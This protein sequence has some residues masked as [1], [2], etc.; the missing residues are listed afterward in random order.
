MALRTARRAGRLRTATIAFAAASA[1]VVTG[2]TNTDD[3]Q[4]DSAQNSVSTEL[5]AGI[6]AAITAALDYST[7]TAAIVGVWS[8]GGDYV[9]AYGDE[10]TVVSQFRGAQ[11][12]QP[13]MCALL[14]DLAADG[15]V[16]LTR[17]VS[18]DLPRQVGIA[19]IT[20][21]QLCT[22]Q[23]GLADFKS[24]FT[25]IV[26][27]NP[28]REWADREL[29]AQSLAR[30]PLSWP[31]LNVHL[32]DTNAVLLERALSVATGIPTNELLEERVFTPAG[33]ASSFYP[34]EVPGVQTLPASGMV[35]NVYPQAGGT[36]MCGAGPT[37]V[38]ELSPSMLGGAGAAVTTV[39]DLK[40]FYEHYL[41]GAY[42][43]DSAATITNTL[44]LQNPP[45]DAEGVPTEELEIDPNARQ[46]G[47][48]LERLG[49]LYGMSGSIPGT[50]TASYHDPVSDFTVV[51]TLNNSSTGADFAR[52]LAQQLSAIAAEHGAGPEVPW[53]SADLAASLA[54]S[55]ICLPPPPE[56]GE[57]AA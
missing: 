17:E 15:T 24:G 10:A 38:H 42:G 25:D 29:L 36:L 37:V 19:G 41:G 5:A 28:T 31:G 47:F 2:C 45:R 22:A 55:A 54:G 35:G 13:V 56:E 26:A 1:L 40:R 57:P 27:N 49:P 48:G 52:R 39:T 44:P 43:E 14:L 32:S 46:W 8:S 11:A 7:A 20:Y 33:M 4:E 3:V 50:I 12:T 16:P 9:T 6:D 23:S 30:S 34:G 53:A 51:V 18:E 21:G